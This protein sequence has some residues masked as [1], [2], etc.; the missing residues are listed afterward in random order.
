MARESENTRTNLANEQIKAG[1]LA[2]TKRSN[3]AKETETN[4][5][6]LMNEAETTRS[7]LVKEAIQSSTAY[8]NARHNV[9]T[10]EDTDKKRT[11]DTVLGGVNAVA[12]IISAIG[13]LKGK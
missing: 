8:E 3:L 10:E 13:K 4:R 11:S 7:N 5:S 9:E 6:N 1:S 12:N 2:E